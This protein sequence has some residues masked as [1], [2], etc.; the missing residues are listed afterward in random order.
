MARNMGSTDVTRIVEIINVQA[1]MEADQFA[2][3]P[4]FHPFW[5]IEILE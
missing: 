4:T 2:G 5:T 1:S 3:V